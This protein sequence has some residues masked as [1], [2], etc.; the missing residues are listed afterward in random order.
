MWLTVR[1]QKSY[2]YTGGKPFDANLPT[3]VFIHGA[4]HDHSVWILQSRYLAHHGYGVL[5]VDLPGHVKSEGTPLATVENMAQW[6]F[7]LLD[8]AGAQQ[9]SLVG[10]SM[11]SLIAL[12]AAGAQPARVTKLALIGTAAPMQVGT[13]LLTATRDDEQLAQDMVNIWSH[14]T[15]A[16]KP[17]SPGPGFWTLGGN[18]RLMQRIKPGVMHTD[19]NACTTYVQG[20]ARAAEVTC[21]AL[22]LLGE[23]D[24]MTMPR[25]ADELM[26]ALKNARR[27]VIPACGHRLMAER[28]DVVLD[29]LAQFLRA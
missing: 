13:G 19:F 15:Y 25:A 29:E 22:L 8:A 4:Q 5:A 2:A 17:S 24:I 11:G 27:V 9:A 28:P 14:S 3:V 7:N 1:G 20:L 12:E 18:L 6:I 26:A 23:N 10:H 16:A 21:P